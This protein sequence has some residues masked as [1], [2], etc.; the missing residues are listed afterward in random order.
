MNQISKDLRGFEDR[1]SPVSGHG[2][3]EDE[4]SRVADAQRPRAA[5]IY[6][7]IRTEGENELNRP[8]SSLWWSGVAA[9]ISIGFSFVGQAGMSAY[10]PDAVWRPF[11]A[12]F[13]YAL[14]FLIVI[15]GRQQLFTENVLTAVLPVISRRKLSWLLSMLRLWTIVLTANMV[16]CL[17]FAYAFAHLPFTSGAIDVQMTRLVHELAAASPLQTFAKGIGGGW[18][19]AALVWILAA[20]EGGDF[21][22]ITLLTYFV[23]ILGFRHIVADTAEALYGWFKYQISFDTFVC[24]FLAY[25]CW[26]RLWRN[27]SFF[28]AQLCTG[29]RGNL[30]GKQRQ[31]PELIFASSSRSAGFEETTMSSPGSSPMPPVRAFAQWPSSP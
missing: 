5:V 2:L 14:G 10:L 21:L 24:L 28:V 8:L 7:I 26:K 25:A 15:L 11:V 29:A 18:L 3:S 17:I 27:H 13:G 31:A 20:A 4:R 23:A 16:G 12:S 1:E 30:P 9:G 6:E 19:I 22:I